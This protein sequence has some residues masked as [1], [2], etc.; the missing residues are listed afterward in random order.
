MKCFRRP[1]TWASLCLLSVLVWLFAPSVNAASVVT[2]DDARIEFGD[3]SPTAPRHLLALDVAPSPAPGKTLVVSRAAVQA[4]LRR[5]GA[6]ER[7]ANSLPAQQRVRRAS[8]RLSIK[9]LEHFV[10]SAVAP[11]L[12]I[13]VTISGISGLRAPVLPTG[14]V[15][16]K[17]RLGQ[18]RRATRA[19]VSVQVDDRI[20]ATM[21]ATLV[22]SGDPRA[23][24]LRADLPKGSV[25]RPAD[26]S[27]E[28]TE[29]SRLPAKSIVRQR[30]LVGKR[31]VQP[32]KAG[33]PIQR[34][35]VEVPP[36][37]ERGSSVFLVAIGRGLRISRRATAQEDGRPGE[38]IRVET[39]EGKRLLKAKVIG[40][41]EVRIDLGGR[42]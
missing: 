5:A 25:V 28:K 36:V 22:L 35:A 27:L 7:L 18:L 3:I 40:P 10:R 41:G 6:D 8:V 26:V 14:D 13:G 12:P 1:P 29:L 42:R 2:V 17:V 9:Q 11:E 24:A 31:L 30:Q 19:A 23:P 33:R 38:M 34:S 39:T 21:T 32:G 20:W 16:V 15:A 4:A 37:I